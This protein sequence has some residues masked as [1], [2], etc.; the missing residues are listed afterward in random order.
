MFLTC[1]H[2]D[3]TRVKLH[4][5]ISYIYHSK[6]FH[7]VDSAHEYFFKALSSYQGSWAYGVNIV[8][9]SSHATM[10]VLLNSNYLQLKGV[11]MFFKCGI[12]IFNIIRFDVHF[13]QI[14]NYSWRANCTTYTALNN[15][16]FYFN[17][18]SLNASPYRKIFQSKVVDLSSIRHTP[19]QFLIRCTSSF[20]IN[21][22]I[23]SRASCEEEHCTDTN[24][25]V[26]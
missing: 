22:C 17:R 9:S 20:K 8:T 21:W 11:H 25:P 5:F 16:R 13:F 7:T 10:L 6:R 2:T 23:S 1:H 12:C 14:K 18:I 4:S 19:S 24:V 15:L 3:F 26:L